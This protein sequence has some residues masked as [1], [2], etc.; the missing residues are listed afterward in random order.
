MPHDTDSVDYEVASLS[1]GPNAVAEFRNVSKYFGDVQ[2][3]RDLQLRIGTGEFLSFLGPSGCGKTT[4]LRMLAGF[5]QPSKGDVLIDNEV[6]NDLEPYITEGTLA[7]L[8]ADVD[9][10][11]H[12]A[13]VNQHI[14]E[15]E[16]EVDS[17]LAKRYTVPVPATV[18]K[19]IVRAA[20][21]LSVEGLYYRGKGPPEKVRQRCEQIRA[22][23]KDVAK[24]VASISD[25][26]E[27][28]S[29]TVSS[30]AFQ[31]E[32]DD[33]ELTRSTLEGL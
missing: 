5:E 29:T 20:G 6:V 14:D 10:G 7:N 27:S 25:L 3:A 9:S 16:S 2:A 8:L 22:W 12:V 15:A 1:G 17:Y 33:R 24:G 23:L 4:A 13:T 21:Y 19:V 30:G 26:T 31:V 11:D 32:A 18:P 28:P